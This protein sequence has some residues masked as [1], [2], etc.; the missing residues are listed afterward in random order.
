GAVL[1]TAQRCHQPIRY[2]D[3]PV[4]LRGY[5]GPIRQIAVD[6]LGRQKLTRFLTNHPQETARNLII[7][8]PRRNCV[9]DGLRLSVNFF[10]VDCLASAVRVNVDRDTVLTVLA[11]GCYRWLGRRRRGDEKAAPKQL[12]RWFVETGGMVKVED[13]EIMVRFD[14]R[15]QNPILREAARD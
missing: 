11:H 12:D 15:S 8:Y 1:D 13:E 14:R 5:E 6:G 10:P 4:K 2:L 9:E 3:E 7:G